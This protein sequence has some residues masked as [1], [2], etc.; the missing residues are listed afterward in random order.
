MNDQIKTYHH[1]VEWSE[2]DGCFIGRCPDL[3][4]GGCHG[5][6]PVRVYEELVELMNEVAKDYADGGKKLPAATYH[7][8]TAA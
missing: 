2:E 4:G 5:D 1:W 8:Q 7:P 6:Q 3:F